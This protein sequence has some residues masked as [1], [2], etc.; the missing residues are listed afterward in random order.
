MRPEYSLIILTVLAGAGQGLFI[1]LVTGDMAGFAKGSRAPQSAV[2]LGMAAVFGLTL[3]GMAASFFHLSHKA[4]GIKAINKWRFS[5]LSR[6]V[7]LLPVFLG[8]AGLYALAGLMGSHPLLIQTLGVGGALVALALF[9]STAMIY[10]HL[11]IIREWGTA[12]TPANFTLTG[13]ITGGLALLAVYGQAMAPMGVTLFIMR[14][15]FAVTAAGLLV[16]LF[17]Y[18][19]NAHKYSPTTIQTALGINHPQIRLMDTGAA[20]PHYNTLEYFYTGQ[21][22]IRGIMRI[23]SILLL[24]IAPGGLIAVDY[25]SLLSAGTACGVCAPLAALSALAGAFLER[26]LFF[27]DGN[28]AQNL[29][30]GVYPAQG[31]A[32]PILQAGKNDAP[33]PP[34]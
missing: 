28:H 12:F 17:Y 21:K 27:V 23:A 13:M 32:N 14:I 19:G 29:Y 7:V 34:A 8:A 22:E 3:L 2:L 31:R 6:E 25:M 18:L 20:Y 30:Y 9:V 5:W 4:R 11:Q 33:L 1:F 26:W 10:G 16:K 15:L 24:Y